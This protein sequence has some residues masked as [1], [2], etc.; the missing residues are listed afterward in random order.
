MEHRQGLKHTNV[1]ALSRRPCLDS[2]CKH[3]VRQEAKEQ[4]QRE[5]MDQ[6]ECFSCQS[7][8]TNE[9][10]D[11]LSKR[12]SSKELRETPMNIDPVLQWK[13]HEN[14][15]PPW[16]KVTHSGEKPTGLNG[17]AWLGTVEY[18]TACGR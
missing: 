17:N 5:E 7:A 6:D 11:A 13:A 1:D 9:E 10:A 16:Q 15:R 3:C 14:T 4:L 18:F 12:L 2:N 8:C